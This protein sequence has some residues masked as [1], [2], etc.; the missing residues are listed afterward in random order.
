MLMVL[1]A[2]YLEKIKRAAALKAAMR[3][4]RSGVIGMILAAA[5]VVAMTAQL[6]WISALIFVAALVALL[7]F[8]LEVAWII[9]CAGALGLMLY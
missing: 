4:I 7:R 3:G 9:P 5:Y 1:C 2:R 8:K 6:N